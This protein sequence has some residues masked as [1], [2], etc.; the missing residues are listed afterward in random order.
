MASVSSSRRPA[1]EIGLVMAGAISAGAYT[2][3]VLDFLIEALDQWYAAH[4][5]NPPHDVRLRVMS[6]ASAGGM[7]GSIL[8]AAL[9]GSEFAPVRERPPAGVASTNALYRAWV[10]DIDIE[11]LLKSDDLAGKRLMSALDSTKLREIAER[12]VDV[13]PAP[14]PIFERRPYLADPFELILSVANLRGVPYTLE[15]KGGAE[16]MMLHAD[17]MHFAIGAE[18]AGQ[19]IMLDTA[20][21]K[22]PGWRL[23]AKA[24]LATGAFPF[25]LAPHTLERP[26]KYY[27]ALEWPVSHFAQGAESK[28]YHKLTPGWVEPG[29]VYEFL[30]VDGGLLNNE[31]FEHAHRALRPQAGAHGPRQ[32]GKESDRAVILIA[33]FAG[34]PDDDYD[35]PDGFFSYAGAVLTSLMEQVRFKPEELILALDENV[36]SRFLISPRRPEHLKKGDIAGAT[37]AGFGGFLHEDFRAHDFLL[38][39]RN[40]QKFLKSRFILPCGDGKDD[41]QGNPLF[42]DWDEALRNQYSRVPKDDSICHLPIIPLAGTAARS[43]PRPDWPAY[44]AFKLKRLTRQMSSRITAVSNA[45]IN[46]NVRDYIGKT[47]LKLLVRTQKPRLLRRLRRYVENNLRDHGIKMII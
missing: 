19:A 16:T 7:A 6:G 18:P 46:E 8:I 10:Q 15:F 23:L 36:Y 31:P 28:R 9:G 34:E 2:A 47:A 40:C 12:S 37:L 35:P 20:N 5:G 33:P 13:E 45:L 41:P 27:A 21:Y 3:G 26:S 39:R 42:R 1:F 17:H 22:T 30:C 38:G 14:A 24:T 11:H 4:D 25:G 29:E 32:G 44:P 43:C